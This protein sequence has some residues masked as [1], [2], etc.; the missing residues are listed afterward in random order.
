[1]DAPDRRLT[2][3]EFLAGLLRLA[4]VLVLLLALG[5]A[6]GV[7]LASSGDGDTRRGIAN[8]LTLVGAGVLIFAAASWLH[9]GPLR[10]DGWRARIAEQDERRDSERLALG[11][12]AIG[13]FLF[14]LAFL[15]A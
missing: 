4:A 1:M 12:V 8:G 9:T 13:A 7:L 10:R 3:E 5:V 6:L 11:L 2:R 15:L 14:V